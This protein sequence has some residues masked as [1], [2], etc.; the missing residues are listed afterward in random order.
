MKRFLAF[1]VIASMGSLA[2]GC[3]KKGEQKTTTETKKIETTDGKVTDEQKSTTET[4][5]APPPTTDK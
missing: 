4:K 2:V 5:T 1:V 3:D